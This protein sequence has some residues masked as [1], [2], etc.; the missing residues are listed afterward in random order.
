MYDCNKSPVSGVSKTENYL[1]YMVSDAAG[2]F[3]FPCLPTGEYR[4]VCHLDCWKGLLEFNF[5]NICQF[6]DLKL[7]IQSSCL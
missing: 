4:L 1:C 3:V 2:K 6:D 7:C 5:T